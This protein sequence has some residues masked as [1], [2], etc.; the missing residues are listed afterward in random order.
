[1]AQWLRI[2]QIDKSFIYLSCSEGPRASSEATNI[3]LGCACGPL[4]EGEVRAQDPC[5]ERT[6]QYDQ[7]S[8]VGGCLTD[9]PSHNVDFTKELPLSH[10]F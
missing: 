1:M 7:G 9:T 2:G 6:P 8:R 3:A 5:Q 4:Q 10:D